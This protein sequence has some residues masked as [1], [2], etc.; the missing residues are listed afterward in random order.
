MTITTNTPPPFSEEQQQWLHEHLLQL[1]QRAVQD[2]V[3]AVLRA[4]R[5]TR[6]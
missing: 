6:P 5:E 2:A 4:Q 1:H 3:A